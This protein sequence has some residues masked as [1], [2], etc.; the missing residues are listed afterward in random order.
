LTA[1][2]QAMRG[3]SN[4]PWFFNLRS[5][6][7][8]NPQYVALPTASATPHVKGS[9]TQ[10]VA[11]TPED[12]GVLF[13]IASGVAVAATET[14][15]L[16]D[17]AVGAAGSEVAVI[18]N[19]AVGGAAV[20]AGGVNG[21]VAPMPVRTPAGSR[22]SCRIQSLIASDT[23]TVNVTL[24]SVP[25][26]QMLPT[27]VDTI[28]T[29]TANSRATPFAGSVGSWTEITASTT[30]RYRGI[31][32]VPSV[33]GTDIASFT[34]DLEI[35]VG[36]AGS[37]VELGRVFADFRNTESV[38]HTTNFLYAPIACDIPA[39]SRLAVK[40]PVSANPE[41]YGVCLIGIP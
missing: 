20:R 40:T 21:V 33:I 1:P 32:L 30:R 27:S 15:M 12:S 35:A 39:G 19:L 41:R 3:L 25:G 36:A 13:L 24:S 16:L 7:H 34:D 18:E 8:S 2:F 28:G 38:F 22:I 37:E 14:S 29:N 9:W 6:R 26:L 5:F 4:V 17:I 23:C 10:V 11:S 31:F